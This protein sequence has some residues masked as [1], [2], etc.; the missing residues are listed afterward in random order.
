M[1]VGFGLGLN[2]FSIVML[3]FMNAL[4]LLVAFVQAYVFTMLSAVF[5]GLAHKEHHAE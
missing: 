1:G 4:E 3:L 2:A 5:I